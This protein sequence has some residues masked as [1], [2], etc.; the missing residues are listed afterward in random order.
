MFD[1]QYVIQ[2]YVSKQMVTIKRRREDATKEKME[3]DAKKK[4]KEEAEEKT[5]PTRIA[6]NS[7][8]PTN[9]ATDSQ[10]PTQHN[11]IQSSV[12]PSKPTRSSD[13]QPVHFTSPFTPFGATTTPATM[14]ST[15]A[16]DARILWA[17]C[18]TPFLRC[19]GFVSIQHPSGN[20]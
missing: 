8:V 5:R 19:V 17:G 16:P 12:G 14:P 2:R 18:C 13:P 10:M 4:K 1:L 6:S 11:T 7:K 20:H 9:A 3:A 15:A